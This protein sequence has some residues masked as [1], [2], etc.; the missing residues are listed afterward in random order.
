MTDTAPSGREPVTF[1]EIRF[2]SEEYR[3]ECAL[4]E[5]VLRA[6]L[7]L[8]LESEDLSREEGQLHYGLFGPD[9]ILAACV[10]AVPLSATAVAVRQMA[11]APSRQRRGLGRRL[12]GELE[13]RLRARGFRR[14]E[15]KARLSAAG[16]Y[17]EL[18]YETEGAE[19]VEVTI[20]HVRM[21]KILR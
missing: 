5:E 6:P 14:V 1:R 13:D 15:L 12:V 16:F 4:R 11:V 10:V 19:F 7:G 3:L 9:G 21:V 17:E 2:G 20:P 8:S 18:G